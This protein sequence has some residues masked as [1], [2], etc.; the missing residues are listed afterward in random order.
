[1][2]GGHG[3]AICEAAVTLAARGDA[4]AIV[5]ITRGG[6]T[7]RV[8]SALRPPVPIYAATDQPAIARRLALAWGVVPVLA[9]L[10]GDVERG[11]QPHR[12]DARRARRDAGWIGDRARE[13]H[14]RPGAR[15]VEF[16]EAAVRVSES[17]G[18]RTAAS[19]T[20]LTFQ[21]QRSSRYFFSASSADT[22]F[23][24]TMS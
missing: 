4:A 22:Q 3:R 16:P 15:A 5:A 17:S 19:M 21:A 8:L 1:M 18:S 14:A 24:E 11:G 12:R 13:H 20:P 6:K 10:S 23:A 2:L 7:A 9:D